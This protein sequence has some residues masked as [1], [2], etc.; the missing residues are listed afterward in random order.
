MIFV[1][2]DVCWWYLHILSTKCPQN[3][4]LCVQNPDL[5]NLGQ[6]MAVGAYSSEVYI[7]H[8][9][10]HLD[11]FRDIESTENRS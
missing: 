6:D 2:K 3:L 11:R 1:G 9:T 7:T 8:N 4:S 5:L 10:F